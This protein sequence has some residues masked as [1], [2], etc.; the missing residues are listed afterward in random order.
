[1]CTLAESD[2]VAPLRPQ[3]LPA[4]VGHVVGH[5]LELGRLLVEL[6]EHCVGRFEALVRGFV[7]LAL[8]DRVPLLRGA[9]DLH[10]AVRVRLEADSLNVELARQLSAA[11]LLDTEF[12]GATVHAEQS[13]QLREWARVV[14]LGLVCA[15]CV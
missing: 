7:E 5:N 4:L 11:H 14:G 6:P 1:M 13:L 10:N 12:G 2:V 3:H 9:A 8:Q 15:A